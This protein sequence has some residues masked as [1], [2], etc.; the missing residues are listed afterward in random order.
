[1]MYM[2]TQVDDG[3]APDTSPPET[4][5][6]LLKLVDSLK[7]EQNGRFLNVDGDIFPW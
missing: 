1:M 2:N 4:V 5:A 3:H 6:K 7:P